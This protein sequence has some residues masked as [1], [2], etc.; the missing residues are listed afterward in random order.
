MDGSF[1]RGW[2]LASLVSGVAGATYNLFDLR[3][4]YEPLSPRKNAFS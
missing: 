4:V 2:W 1:S 3:S